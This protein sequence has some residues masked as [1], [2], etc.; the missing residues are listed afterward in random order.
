MPPSAPGSLAYSLAYVQITAM[1]DELPGRFV[2]DAAVLRTDLPLFTVPSE[3]KEAPESGKTKHRRKGDRKPPPQPR[4]EGP[5]VPAP[6][7][8]PELRGEIRRTIREQLRGRLLA[9]ENL[10]SESRAVEQQLTRVNEI[11]RL[12]TNL[13]AEV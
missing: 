10:A 4:K 2:H 3:L 6:E 13:D 11:E 5:V 12:E 1:L 7:I 9:F 8:T